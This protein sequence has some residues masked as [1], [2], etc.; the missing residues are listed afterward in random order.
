MTVEA[1]FSIF[2]ISYSIESQLIAGKNKQN[3]KLL[4]ASGRFDHI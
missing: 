2:S 4:S 3:K 1:E